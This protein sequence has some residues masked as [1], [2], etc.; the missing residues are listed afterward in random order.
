[1]RGIVVRMILVVCLGC[2]LLSGE[3]C[4][5]QSEERTTTNFEASSRSSRQEAA[6]TLGGLQMWSDRLVLHNWRIQQQT[7]TDVCRLLDGTNLRRAHG[8]FEDCKLELERLQRTLE[9][10]PMTGRVIILLHGLG[11][12]RRSMAGLAA[13]LRARSDPTVVNLSY[14]S[15]RHNIGRHAESLASVMRHLPSVDTVDLVAHSM[16]N[17]VIRHCWADLQQSSEDKLLSRIRRVVM[18]CPPNR[19][20]IM[21]TR[22]K[23]WRMFQVLA[24]A[25]GQQIA[26]WDSLTEK[27]AKPSCEF[28]IL[29]GGR[30]K[31]RG[32]NPLIAGDNDLV[33]GVDET[34]LVGARD[35]AVIPSWHTTVMNDALAREYV[36]RF[37]EQG[38]F[39]ASGERTPI[40]E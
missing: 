9:L 36:L 15:T 30:G 14:A 26:R 37:L 31:S 6:P 38:H 19:G 21:A 1:M 10:R 33:V 24:G 18:L 3:A 12:T 29:A 5:V 28:G 22:F 35:F 8:T 4:Q 25:S 17:L 39:R 16:G 2:N 32:F 34:K 20:A 7:S 11:R 27:L 13:Y 40:H 23:N